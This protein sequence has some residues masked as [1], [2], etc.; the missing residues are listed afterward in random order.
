MTDDRSCILA[1]HSGSGAVT[2][3]QIR[4]VAAVVDRALAHIPVRIPQWLRLAVQLAAVLA[5]CFAFVCVFLLILIYGETHWLPDRQMT[6]MAIFTV[7]VFGAVIS[8]FKGW[9]RNWR[10]WLALGAPFVL[11]V[12]ACAVLWSRRVDGRTIHYAMLSLIEILMLCSALDALG[13][14]PWRITRRKKHS[15]RGE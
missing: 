12:S 2:S 5:G 11:H 14:F 13:F 10:F 1:Q 4:F 3:S 15:P 6:L 8:E 9:R 7:V